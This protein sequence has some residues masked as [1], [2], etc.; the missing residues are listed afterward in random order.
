MPAEQVFEF[1][2]RRGRQVKHFL[3][4][5]TAAGRDH[6]ERALAIAFTNYNRELQATHV[7]VDGGLQRT[8]VSSPQALAPG[9]HTIVYRFIPDSEKPADGGTSRLS[10]DGKQVDEKHVPRTMPFA[11]SADEGVDVGRDDETPVTE[12]YKERDNRFAGKIHR[13]TVE[14]K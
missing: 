3:V 7:A 1:G 6:L 12:D 13:V 10:V 5:V 14:L 11:Y 8:T 4:N 2:Y 9:R